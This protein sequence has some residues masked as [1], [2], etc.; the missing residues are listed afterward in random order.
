VSVFALQLIKR[1]LSTP[2]TRQQLLRITKLPERT[3]RYNLSILK[4]KGIVEEIP[5]FSDL[6]RKL[7]LLRR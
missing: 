7:F 5:V 2:K 6:R 4:K 3:L 1:A